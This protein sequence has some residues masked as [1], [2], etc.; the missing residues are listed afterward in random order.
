MQ[1]D[2]SRREILR[3]GFGFGAIT[4]AGGPVVAATHADGNPQEPFG[5]CL[6]LATIMGQDLP[7]DQEIE[8][9]SR[10]GYRGVEIW[11]RNLERYVG[12]RGTPSDLKKRIADQGLT[13]EGAI[14][15]A[16]WAV[17][18]DAQ[19][20]EGLE[21]LRREMDLLAQIGCKRV[22]APPAGL[23]NVSGVDL[24]Q[25]ASRYRAILEMG[26]VAGVLPQLEVWGGSKTL[27]RLSEAAFVAIEAAHPDACLLLDA[28][29]LYR[30]GNDFAS[31]KQLNGAAMRVFHLNDYPAVPP[32][33]T[34]TDA[35]RIYPGYGICPLK[36]VL[37]MLYTT[38]FRGMLSLELFNKDLWKQDPLEVARTGLAKM[39]SLVRSAFA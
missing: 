3:A 32:R 19:R 33:E 4:F 26:R 16:P 38:G 10:A 9:A 12:S 2:L 18:D 25:L 22:A 5:Y 37:R 34:I 11:T 6:N 28:Y 7:L 24:R 21:T 20:A 31:L 23:H 39:K 17:E 15:F 14:G 1:N 35:H 13:V 27:S 36:D 29:H 8:V 30:G